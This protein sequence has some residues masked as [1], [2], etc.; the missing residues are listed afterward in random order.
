[1]EEEFEDEEIVKRFGC[2]EC[3]HSFAMECESADMIPRFC[4]FCASP[5]YSRDDEDLEWEGDE[6]IPFEA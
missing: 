3:G 6:D 1:M 2:A 5:V 4:P